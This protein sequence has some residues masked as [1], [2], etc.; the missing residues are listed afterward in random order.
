M[1]REM[2]GTLLLPREGMPEAH[3]PYAALRYGDYRCLLTGSILVSMGLEMQA[4]A[5]GWELYQRTNSA[6]ALGY[7]GLCQFLPVLLLSLPAGQVADRYSRKWQLVIAQLLTMVVSLALALLSFYQGPIPLVYFCLFLAGVSRALG[8]PARWALVSQVVPTH[9]LN[10]AVTWNSSGWQLATVT[11]PMLGG[12]VMA[13]TH[14]AAEVYLMTAGCALACVGLLLPIRP[15]GVSL[16]RPV[17]LSSLLEGVRFVWGTKLILA[18]ITL[19]LFAV[20]LGGATALLPIYAP[21]F[22][23]SVPKDWAGCVRH[24]PREP[25]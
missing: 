3:D 2:P 11:G 13:R 16:R 23:R 17:S 18:T 20:L 14:A 6:A 25:C 8:S 5:V 1:C 15:Q 4:V 9:V 24:P 12:M 7:V 19:D 22:S 21:I 10:N